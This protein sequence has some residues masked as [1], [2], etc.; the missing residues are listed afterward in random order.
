[1]D[2]ALRATVARRLRLRRLRWRILALLVAVEG[3]ALVALTHDA[4]ALVVLPAPAFLTLV[5]MLFV[6]RYRLPNDECESNPDFAGQAKL[7]TECFATHTYVPL[8]IRQDVRED[9]ALKIERRRRFRGLRSKKAFVVIHDAEVYL[10]VTA[11]SYWVWYAR[12]LR[13]GAI[14]S[15]GIDV[16]EWTED[17]EDVDLGDEIVAKTWRHSTKTG[18]RDL[19]YKRNSEIFEVRRHGVTL[20]FDD[21]AWTIRVCF[22]DDACM[23]ANA[24][25]AIAGQG[26]ALTYSNETAD[27]G[28]NGSNE[29]ASGKQASGENEADE[30]EDEA[31]ESEQDDGLRAWHDVLGTAPDASM[32]V[33]KAAY[34]E[35]LKE[36]HPDRVAHLGEKLRDLADEEAIAINQAY[37][38]ALRT[39][40]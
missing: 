15:L 8:D 4:A 33:I 1:M 35:R 30:A 26:P 2:D 7:L 11:R 31:S 37:A 21:F 28:T 19:R 38:E 10:I 5:P 3:S 12:K 23:F 36:Y 14:G 25:S 18:K 40:R 16:V 32:D 24:F 20:T 27:A 13:F 29:A 9:A 6:G 22:E 17:V 34:R 39:R